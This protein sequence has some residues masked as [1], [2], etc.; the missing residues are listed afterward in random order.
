[1]QIGLVTLDDEVLWLSN[2][3]TAVLHSRVIALK[4]DLRLEDEVGILG[5]RHL[6]TAA[7]GEQKRGRQ[8]QQQESTDRHRIPTTRVRPPPAG[9]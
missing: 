8:R 2:Q 3:L 5:Q 6:V 7:C 4:T 1:M 9:W